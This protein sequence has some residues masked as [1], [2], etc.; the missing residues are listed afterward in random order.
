M[1]GMDRQNTAIQFPY[2][3]PIG[4]AAR[5]WLHNLDKPWWLENYLHAN[6]WR[7]KDE[8]ISSSQRINWEYPLYDPAT[9]RVSLLTDPE[10]ADLLEVAQLFCQAIRDGQISRVESAKNQ[11]FLTRQLMGIFAW[12]RLNLVYS[13]DQLDLIHF[14][15]FMRDAPWG[16]VRLLEMDRRLEEYVRSLR[17]AGQKM[18][19]RISGKEIDTGKIFRLIGVDPLLSG[20]FGKN[21]AYKLWN[22][23]ADLNGEDFVYFTHLDLI[24][25][26]EEPKHAPLTV[27]S[28]SKYVWTWQL[29][30]DMGHLLPQKSRVN[31]SRDFVH[32]EELSSIKIAAEAHKAANIEYDNG[33]TETIPDVQGF[34]L[35]DRAI[36]WVLMYSY[37]LLELRRLAVEAI[38]RGSG[39]D[40]SSALKG[41]KYQRFPRM[42]QNFSPKQFSSDD[43]GAPWPL[44]TTNVKGS[45]NLSIVDATGRYLMAACAIVIVA[46]S[47]RRK[48]EILTIKGG[49]PTEE[50][51]APRAIFIDQDNEPW[52]WCWIEKTYQKW[53]RMP[54]PKLIVKAVEV[55]EELTTSTRAKNNS[56][57]LFELEMLTTEGTSKFNFQN[58]IN[59]FADFVQVPPLKDGSR[60]VF[61]PHQF[62]RFFALLYMYRYNYGEHGKFEALSWHLR[63]L[64]MEMT[65]R[66]IEEIHQTDMMKAHTKHIVVDLMSE[67]LR[68]ERKA[69][70]PGGEAMKG[71]LNEMLREVIKGSE[72]LGGKE[73]PSVARKIAERVMLK[74]DIEMVPFMWGYCYAYKDISDGTFHGNCIKDGA[75]ANVPDLARATPKACFGCKHL[76]VDDNFH[77][78]WVMGAKKYQQAIDGGMLSDVMNDMA[79]KN[80]AVFVAALERYF[81]TACGS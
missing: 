55:L 48:M 57:N 34:H 81:D 61:K 63:H 41:R 21:F 26:P 70:G 74:L 33:I 46:F 29:M 40:N 3:S 38:A 79:R 11:A 28:T 69:A 4:V 25:D 31:P 32:G 12:M 67:V 17:A 7:V 30:H 10:N 6:E 77:S 27:I 5:P 13:L 35:L 15:M 64:D 51:N 1:Y 68:K 2:S 39:S 75:D 65:K 71:Q 9:Q 54:I 76:Y 66:Y 73:N 49:E 47:A 58:S 8:G 16:L 62:R 42:L 22:A 59:L 52:L 23:A 50:D 20:S 24:D 36:R 37:D 72:I 80:L 60:W 14:K 44:D 53:D 19:L 56:R 18:P 43:P 78:Y 45:R